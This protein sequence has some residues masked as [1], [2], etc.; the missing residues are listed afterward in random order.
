MLIGV[1]VLV[2][3]GTRLGQTLAAIVV[4]I[5]GALIAASRLVLPSGAEI[6]LSGSPASRTED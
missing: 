4:L 3:F 6:D 5:G 2:S 1:V